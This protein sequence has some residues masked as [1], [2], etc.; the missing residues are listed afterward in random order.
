MG[1]PLNKH[2]NTSH[3]H[4]LHGFLDEMHP[5]VALI[6]RAGQDLHHLWL[7]NACRDEEEAALFV[8]DLPHNQLLKGDD[9]GAL[10]LQGEEGWVKEGRDGRRQRGKRMEKKR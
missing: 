3:L 8:S 10:V 2:I 6:L 1:K 4:G 9:C 5:G 7:L